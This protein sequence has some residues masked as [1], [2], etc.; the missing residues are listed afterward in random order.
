[1]TEAESDSSDR[2]SVTLTKA[3]WGVVVVG[4]RDFT[5]T[6]VSF[7]L[8]SACNQAGLGV[9]AIFGPRNHDIASHINS[10]C[11]TLE[12]PHIEVRLEPLANE[13]QLFSMNLYPDTAR[14]SSAFMDLLKHFKWEKFVVIYGD[15]NGKVSPHITPQSIIACLTSSPP[16]FICHIPEPR[17]IFTM[18]NHTKWSSSLLPLHHICIPCFQIRPSHLHDEVLKV[19]LLLLPTVLGLLRLIKS[20]IIPHASS[21]NVVKLPQRSI[22]NW[23]A[24]SIGAVDNQLIKT[25]RALMR[26]ALIDVFLAGSDKSRHQINQKGAHVP[27]SID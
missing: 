27:H 7:S 5:L 18:P 20:F 25:Q 26:S 11:N 6:Y 9:A 10:M 21:F 19:V 3:L 14:L 16:Q 1:M 22:I 2:R 4:S 17:Y 23:L 24:K 12:I 8:F 15:Q 13:V